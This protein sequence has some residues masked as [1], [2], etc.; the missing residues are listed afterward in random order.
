MYKSDTLSLVPFVAEDAQDL[1]TM[2]VSNKD[3]FQHYFPNTLRQNLSIKASESYIFQKQK[4]LKNNIEYTFAIKET[5]TNTIVGIIILKEIN[6]TL[7]QGEFA[8]AI[9]Q[10]FEGKGWT[11]KAVA[12]FSDYAF[13]N[14]GIETIQ[15]IV[16]KSNIASI[17]VAEKNSY[18]WIKTLPNEFTPENSAPL[19]MELYELEKTT[20]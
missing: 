11:S 16:H 13:S 3:R 1:C 6:P 5:A 10:K 8:Y 9:D 2:M 7:K 19:D 15:I 20:A 12:I 18:R 17:K 4:E 14:L